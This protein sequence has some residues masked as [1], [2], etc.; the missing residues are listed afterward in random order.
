LNKNQWTKPELE[1]LEIGMTELQ[2]TLGAG[3]DKDY[4]TGTPF[5]DLTWS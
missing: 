5:P 1:I 3:L 4:P 2:P